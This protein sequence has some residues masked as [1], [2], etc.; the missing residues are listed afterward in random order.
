MN[1]FEDSID[2]A[3]H[4]DG[5][6]TEIGLDDDIGIDLVVDGNNDKINE[7]DDE[8]CL[9]KLLGKRFKSFQEVQEFCKLFSSKTNTVLSIKDSKKLKETDNVDLSLFPYLRLSYSCGYGTRVRNRG[10]GIRANQSTFAMGCPFLLNF[11]FSKKLLQYTISKFI[12]N[13]ENHDTSEMGAKFHPKNRRLSDE[14]LEKYVKRDI[15]EIGAKKHH[16]KLNI[17]KETGKFVTSKDLEN[18]LQR[19]S[20]Y[21]KTDDMKEVISLLETRH[22]SESGSYLKLFYVQSNHKDDMDKNVLKG[23]FWQSN[24]MKILF[25]KFGSIMFMDATYGLTNRG[26]VLVAFNIIDNH[27]NSR[28]IAWA[29]LANEQHDLLLEALNVFKAANAE[30]V[31][32]LKY[33]VVDKDF[34]EIN[35][36]HKSLPNVHF[37]ICRFHALQAVS[38]YVHQLHLPAK[39]QIL[40]KKMQDL[41]REM[42]YAPTEALY[43][44]A[45]QRLCQLAPSND[46]VRKAIDYFERNWHNCREHWAKYLLKEEEILNSYTNNRAE[47]FNSVVKRIITKNS[48]IQKVVQTLFSLE[49]TQNFNL[50]YK[51]WINENKT[52]CPQD[53][54]DNDLDALIKIG[55]KFLTTEVLKKLKN[56]YSEI[57]SVSQN[58]V[59]LE[60]GYVQCP[61][62]IGVCTFSRTNNLPCRHLFYV[63]HKN[64]E[65]ILTQEMFDS[66]WLK[67]KDTENSCNQH[68]DFTEPVYKKMKMNLKER[69]TN[70]MDAV[71]DITS[72]I[73]EGSTHERNE[74]LKFLND[75]SDLWKRG[76]NVKV[77]NDKVLIVNDNSLQKNESSNDFIF[78]P[79]RHQKL[80]KIFGHTS[81]F[82]NNNGKPSSE[83]LNSLTEWQNNSN[84]ILK[85]NGLP[86][87]LD[88]RDF[89]ILMDSTLVGTSA[90]LND[91]HL[92]AINILLKKDFPEILGLNDT[93][94]YYFQGFSPIPGGK[95]FIQPVHSGHQHW[96]LLTNIGIAEKDRPRNVIL[97]DSFIRFKPN[98]KTSCEVAPAVTWQVSQLLKDKYAS[99]QMLTISILP[100]QQQSNSWDCGVFTIMNAILLAF[101]K[102]PEETYFDTEPL[103]SIICEMIK[104]I[105][106]SDIPST[107]RNKSHEMSFS[108]SVFLGKINKYLAIP[109]MTYTFSV[110]CHCLMPES[111]NNVMFCNNCSQPFH[112]VCYLLGANNKIATRED[113]TF[114]CYNCRKLKDYSFFMAP[115]EINENLIQEISDKIVSLPANKLGTLVPLVLSNKK[116]NLPV[117]LDEYIELESIISTYD[118]TQLTVG[119]GQLLS[120]IKNYYSNNISEVGINKCFEDF[121]I[122]QTTYLAVLLIVTALN[123]G[124]CLIPNRIDITTQCDDVI[125]EG[126]KFE[127]RSKDLL[128]LFNKLHS[129]IQKFCS[130]NTKTYA[131]SMDHLSTFSNNIRLL[132][133]SKDGFEQELA[134][135]HRTAGN[136]KG[137]SGVFQPLLD[138]TKT[139]EDL[140]KNSSDI[141]DSYVKQQKLN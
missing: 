80:F 100:C 41:F 13:H 116:V 53:V 93:C 16:V 91:K 135:F 72:I 2:S 38:R 44:N 3:K 29:M 63:L 106:V 19:V 115:Q 8:F 95:A 126:K 101:G 113:F 7:S 89:E 124:S 51:D 110:I 136:E 117:T 14:E 105:G 20:S 88:S 114:V 62:K 96:S 23:I 67:S 9:E 92:N 140:L 81:H 64:N 61:R 122:A 55:S 27:F 107:P 21:Q 12:P 69:Y 6:E 86:S 18:A 28:L 130:C 98:S 46:I 139:M 112:Q 43:M 39:D 111:W 104:N 36:L 102:K 37:I 11:Y 57:Q 60:K 49:N 26:Y 129:D 54:N 10:K 5:N 133:E 94:L 132:K 47:S 84:K 121:D 118:L 134:N 78:E 128:N 87:V 50:R 79:K 34:C 108:Q 4:K 17:R 83:R 119:E 40:K 25:R 42:L 76:K 68:N 127:L 48:R 138:S 45:W 125:L 75:I 103:R 1:N 33:I 58:E 71:K 65:T 109:K 15:M 123:K 30:S 22:N 131:K 32:H 74:Q 137:F 77:E 66:R 120:A 99:H 141:L 31:S 85:Q 82:N 59:N 52:F 24:D 70:T 97:Y 73:A 35:V 56:E 90:F